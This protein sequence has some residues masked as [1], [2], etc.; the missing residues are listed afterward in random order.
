M[1]DAERDA[2]NIRNVHRVNEFLPL[3]YA[4]PLSYALTYA[5][6]V[7]KRAV[8]HLQHIF[9]EYFLYFTGIELLSDFLKSQPYRVITGTKMTDR[10]SSSYT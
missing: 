2:G 7:F 4:L 9:Y 10:V 3:I 6:F 1:E 8:V 5:I